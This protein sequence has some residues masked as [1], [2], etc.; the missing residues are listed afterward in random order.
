M[1]IHPTFQGRRTEELVRTFSDTDSVVQEPSIQSLAEDDIIVAFGDEPISGIDALHRHLLAP[2]IG[3]P[4]QVTVI[5]HT[6]KLDL[7]VTPEE[8]APA[9]QKN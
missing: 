6:E 7:T 2:A 9:N 5:R 3:I 1:K 4:A 8:L